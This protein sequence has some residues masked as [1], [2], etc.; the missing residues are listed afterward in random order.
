[1]NRTS[2]RTLLYRSLIVYNLFIIIFLFFLCVYV[3]IVFLCGAIIFIVCEKNLNNVES[4]FF[5]RHSMLRHCAQRMR[6][7]WHT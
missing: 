3:Y 6:A 7:H 1:M 2:D 5:S 4:F